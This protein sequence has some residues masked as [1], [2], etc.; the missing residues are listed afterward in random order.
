MSIVCSY[1]IINVEKYLSYYKNK[2]MK[3]TILL[4]WILQVFVG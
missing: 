1:T 2:N 3:I 4:E